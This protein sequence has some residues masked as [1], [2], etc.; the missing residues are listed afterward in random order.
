[1]SPARDYDPGGLLAEVTAG[2]NGAQRAELA[3]R[4][5]AEARRREL[6]A[7]YSSPLA[8]ARALNPRYRITPALERIDAALVDQHAGRIPRLIITMGAQEGKSTLLSLYRPLWRLLKRPSLRMVVASY[9]QGIASR[10]TYAVRQTIATYGTAAT[11]AGGTDVLGLGISR[12]L[13]SRH[14]WQLADWPGGMY[15]A[16]VG[17]ALTGRP[18]DDLGVDDPLRDLSAA[19]SPTIR[20]HLRDWWTGT[21]VERIPPDAPMVIVSTRWH[22]DDL[23]GWLLAEQERNPPP[24]PRFAW[25]LLNFP[26][27]SG[28]KARG[29]PIPDALRR[30]PGE[31]LIS[32]RGRHDNDAADWRRLRREVGAR[33]FSAIYQG[34]P[35]P[36]EGGVWSADTIGAYRVAQAPTRLAR[37]VIA[38]D[39]AET[40]TADESGI[41]AGGRDL[42]TPPH[43]YVLA[44]HSGLWGVD[45]WPRRALLA[46]LHHRADVIVWEANRTP[47]GRR[48]IRTAWADMLRDAAALSAAALSAGATWPE[49]PD[50]NTI[51]AVADALLAVA[52]TTTLLRVLGA[53][54]VAPAP[55]PADDDPDDQPELT[56]VRNRLRLLWPHTRDVLGH[57]S[58][59]PFLLTPVTATRGKLTRAEPAAQ[60][61]SAGRVHHV[62]ELPE[63]EAQQTSWLPGMDSPDRMDAAVW[64]VTYLSGSAGPAR[65]ERP[66][67]LTP[68][69]TRTT[70]RR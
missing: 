2:L 28:Q 57:G 66:D 38:V 39:P 44:D 10:W 51:D 9:Q 49:Q 37:V 54:L 6:A 42:R 18:A 19:A 33:A 22:E 43:I 11:D 23:V 13:A 8:L 16:G 61:Y 25:V 35:V 46:A 59:V 31:W 27:L 20:D 12:D 15:A 58:T 40:G 48:L 52:D 56:R 60:V 1:V 64:L 69:P 34:A 29:R 41:I 24:D 65:V 68:I 5:A 53:K 30:P 32:A 36:T 55:E 17:G 70:T 63:L 67:R 26:A 21:V 47:A 4:L 50:E 62:G 3:R 7:R 45:D 14:E